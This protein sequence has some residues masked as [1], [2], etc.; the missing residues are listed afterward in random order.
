[1]RLCSIPNC[2]RKHFGRGYCA[3]HYA[4]FQK[5]GDPLAGRVEAGVALAWLMERVGHHGEECQEW[6]FPTKQ[7]GYGSLSYHGRQVRAHRLMC[8][9][10]HGEPPADG[11]EAA[12]SCGNRLCVN[13]DHLRWATPKENQADK[14]IHGTHNG[15]S[16]NP[17]AKL[18]EG[19]VAAIRAQLGK[20]QQKSIAERFGVSS[21][22]ISNI[23][24]GKRWANAR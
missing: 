21:G 13:P 4:R 20:E 14:H 12:H 2:N 6:P 23:A 16:R 7:R 15:G 3:M 9:L 5:Y 8:E 22:T 17:M 24:N 10:A 18:D 1:M 19:V 11:L